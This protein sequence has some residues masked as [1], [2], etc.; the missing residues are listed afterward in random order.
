MHNCHLLLHSA[1]TCHNV[2]MKSFQVVAAEMQDVHTKVSFD[3]T[4]RLQREARSAKKELR[5]MFKEEAAKQH[6]R[7]ATP[8]SSII[9]LG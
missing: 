4:Y 1:I 8:P 6:K 7:M 9:P 3:I 5:M 2:C